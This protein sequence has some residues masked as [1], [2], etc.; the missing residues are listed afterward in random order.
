MSEPSVLEMDETEEL[1]SLKRELIIRICPTHCVHEKLYFIACVFMPVCCMCV[2]VR[3]FLCDPNVADQ[4]LRST[5]SVLLG[6]SRQRKESTAACK[7]CYVRHGCYTK[8]GQVIRLLLLME[9]CV[10]V[11]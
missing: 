5:L 7:W 1:E 10:D 8:S 2:C 4:E 9:L 6:A 3:G 11:V